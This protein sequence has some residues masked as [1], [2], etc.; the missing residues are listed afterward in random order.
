M[1]LI[2]DVHKRLRESKTKRSVVIFFSFH[3]HKLLFCSCGALHQ[4][5][6]AKQVGNLLFRNFCPSSHFENSD[7]F[8]QSQSVSNRPSENQGLETFLTRKTCEIIMDG[9]GALAQDPA[10][11]KL[12]AFHEKNGDSINIANLFSADP[13]RFE[14]FRYVITLTEVVC[15]CVK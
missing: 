9:R 10:F 8:C 11:Q 4:K 1:Y 7:L 3:H 13:E 6:S 5:R 14:K 12:K 2:C 15:T